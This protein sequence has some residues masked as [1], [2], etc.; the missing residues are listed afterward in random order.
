MNKA[1][2]IKELKTHLKGRINN[3]ELHDAILYYSELI[4]DR[5][6]LGESENEIII[7][8]GKIDDIVKTISLDSIG[9]RSITKVISSSKELLKYA[10]TPFTIFFAVIF[11]IVMFSLI[12]SLGAVFI[13]F[14]TTLIALTVS[15]I[16]TT[17]TA[18]SNNSEVGVWIF[19]IGAH[20]FA[21]GLILL[22]TILIKRL[23]TYLIKLTMRTFSK[24]LNKEV[25]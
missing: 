9:N 16:S 20:L 15:I 17:S 4:D 3:D 21:F 5:L 13:S 23:V 2:F 12:V 22:I 6:D 10:K 7:S 25:I 19:N 24:V 8:L 11:A 14:I 18:I 1:A